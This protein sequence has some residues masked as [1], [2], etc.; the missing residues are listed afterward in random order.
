MDKILIGER[1]RKIREDIFQESR[2]VFSSK[3]GLSAKHLGQI[4]RG[5]YGASLSALDKLR[6]ATGT[7]IDYIL[8]G[9]EKN[10]FPMKEALN[11]IIEK[12]T[13]AQI[14]MYYKCICAIKDYSQ[15]N[16]SKKK[17]KKT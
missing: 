16:K 7:S 5:E 10:A 12:S 13:D 11:S 2:E 17:S 4:E 3:C 1:I 9:N 14:E 6:H 8:Y 15:E